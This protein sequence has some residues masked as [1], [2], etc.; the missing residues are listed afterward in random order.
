MYFNEARRCVEE[1]NYHRRKEGIPHHS[2]K[3][4]RTRWVKIDGELKKEVLA[5]DGKRLSLPRG[6]R[7]FLEPIASEKCPYGKVNEWG[8]IL[9]EGP[10]K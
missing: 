10:V 5:I 3:K 6:K 8:D 7:L 4:F 1:A 2:E 9:D